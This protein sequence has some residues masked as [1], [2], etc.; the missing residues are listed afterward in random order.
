ML[1]AGGLTF[2]EFAMRE[3]VPLATIH[4]AVL[5]FLR[6]RND[7][8]VFGAQAVN[9]WVGEPR[10]TQDIGLIAIKAEA[11]AQEICELLSERFRIAARVREVKA[12]AGYRVYQIQKAGDRRLVDIRA[13]DTLPPAA[14]I[15]AVW[16]MTPATDEDE[17]F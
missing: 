2:R 1:N 3:Q 7:V 6:D 5:D 17:D 13:T 16:V 10:M 15:E 4:A 12:G 9:A 14:Q 11:L 8:V